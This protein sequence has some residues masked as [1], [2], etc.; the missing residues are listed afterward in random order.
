MF[1][2]DCQTGLMA[3]GRIARAVRNLLKIFDKFISTQDNVAFLRF[4]WFL[5][6]EF[7]FLVI[8]KFAPEEHL[9]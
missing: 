5:F 1:R 4:V 3:G 2:F 7:V 6:H 9:R 8:S